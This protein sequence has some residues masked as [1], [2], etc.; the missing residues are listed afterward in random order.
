[1]Y[2]APL[3]VTPPTTALWLNLWWYYIVLGTAGGVVV[4]GYMVYNIV[5]YRYREGKKA[6]YVEHTHTRWQA[7]KGVLMTLA[8]TGTVLGVVEY[9]SF[10]DVGLIVP[11]DPPSNMLD[12][13]VIGAQFSWT[14]V[15]PNGVKVVDNLTVPQGQDVLLN[16]TSVDVDHSFSLPALDVAKDATPG[17]H[18]I[19]WFDA[20]NLG[21]Y[22]IQCKELCGAGHA[23]MT[24][25]LTVV[26]A[27][28]YDKWYAT[29]GAH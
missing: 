2:S 9:Q 10:A 22:E 7:A 23:F 26:N 3:Y 24:A 29:L 20:T 17:L 8:V 5:K 27:S 21:V 25:Q 11:P 28:A 15:Y 14:F 4:I 13:G 6:T 18:N 12:I 1:M 19:V 16:I